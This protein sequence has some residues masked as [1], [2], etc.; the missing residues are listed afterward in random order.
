MSKYS[1][2]HIYNINKL[3]QIKHNRKL[4]NLPKVEHIKLKRWKTFTYNSEVVKCPNKS[5]NLRVTVRLAEE[6]R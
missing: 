4:E 6:E 5:T 1:C 2:F 3:G